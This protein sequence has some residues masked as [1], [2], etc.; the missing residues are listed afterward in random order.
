MGR[1]IE[2]PRPITHAEM[3]AIEARIEARPGG[4]AGV[5]EEAAEAD[6]AFD[7]DRV[8]EA[9]LAPLPA[10]ELT[11][12]QCAEVAALLAPYAAVDEP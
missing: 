7:Y 11:D 9:A 5:F 3:R 4:W 1:S 12:A 6:R 2:N 8:A 10:F